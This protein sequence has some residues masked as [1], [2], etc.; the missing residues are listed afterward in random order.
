M[1]SK[2]KTVLK[3]VFLLAI[4]SLAIHSFAAWTMPT[5]NPPEG[6]TP[7]PVNT[8]SGLQ[9]KP[10]S[11]LVNLFRVF[12]DAY[13][14]GNVGVG[15]VTPA[16][17]LDV[18]GPGVRFSNSGNGIEFLQSNGTNWQIANIGTNN[19][20]SVNGNLGV[21]TTTPA[22]KLDVAGTVK[23]TGFQLTTG[24]GA[25]KILTSDLNGVATWQTP[26][27][28]SGL[29]AGTNGQT[30]RNNNGTWE[31][32]SSIFNN[33]TNVGI[34]NTNP[35]R[36]LDV[37]GD[38]KFSGSLLPNDSAGLAGQVLMTN[39]SG[40]TPYWSTVVGE[41]GPQGEQGI[42]GIQGIQGNQG[43]QG[44]QGIQ[45]NQGDPGP[46][47][48]QGIQ[49]NQG[50]QG[51]PGPPGSGSMGGGGTAT[52]I[53]KFT[54]ANEL[55]DSVIYNQSD[56]D[57]GINTTSPG[58]R[59]GIAGNLNVGSGYANL[60]GQSNGAIIE[61][62]VG[63]GTSSPSAKLH[64]AG[65]VRIVDGNQSYGDVLTS[66]ANGNAT[67]QPTLVPITGV[68]NATLNYNAGAY[69]ISTFL[70]N[71][72]NQVGVGAGQY[73]PDLF[74][75]GTPGSIRGLM[76]LASGT[77]G[78]AI[79][80]APS[81]GFTTYTL[82]LPTDDGNANQFLKTNG[83]GALSWD[84]VGTSIDTIGDAGGPGT[85]I[86]GNNLQEWTWDTLSSTTGF[87]LSSSTPNPGSG[88]TL[89]NVTMDGTNNGG[90]TAM[91]V[92]NNKTGTANTNV[93]GQFSSTGGLNDYAILVPPNSGFVGIGDSNPV[94]LF[95][96][97]S[98]DTFQV[99]S[100]GNLSKIRG[101]TYAWPTVQGGN[102]QVL[103]NDGNGTLTWAAGGGGGV[104]GSGAAPYIP[105]WTGST[106]L[107]NS[108]IQ[109]TGTNVGIGSGTPAN[110]LD[111]FGGSIRAE[112]S[113][114]I[115]GASSGGLILKETTTNLNDIIK[116]QAPASIAGSYTLTLPTDNGNVDQ[117]LRTDGNGVLS[118]V[119]PASGGGITTLNTLGGAIQ[120]FATGTTGTNF[121]ITSSG[122]T[123]TFNL[124]DASVTN[125]GVVT[126]GTQAFA[127]AKNFVDSP[128]SFG[129]ATGTTAGSIRIYDNDSTG[130]ENIIINPPAGTALTSSYTLTLPTGPGTSGQV[131]STNGSGVLSWIAAGGGLPSGTTNQTLRHNGTTWLA[132]SLITNQG[133]TGNVGIGT[134]SPSNKLTVNENVGN[135]T[136]SNHATYGFALK[137]NAGTTQFTLG[138]NSTNSYIQSWDGQPLYING[139]LNNTTVINPTAGRVGVGTTA[140]T[141]TFQISQGNSAGPGTVM[142]SPNSSTLSGSGTDF[143]NTFAVGDTVTVGA[144]GTRT[145]TSISSATS[146]QINPP[147]DSS[148][149]SGLSYTTPVN[150][151]FAARGNGNIGINNSIPT[152]LLDINGNNIR[153]R[154]AKT[155]AQGSVCDTGEISWDANYM[156]VCTA[157]NVWKRAS[158]TT[159]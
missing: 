116:I 2:I 135:T 10:G 150:T 109:D 152:D 117:I 1:H 37:T 105:K 67:W 19:S 88:G 94:E 38:I 76:S 127:G 130:P 87:R 60:P 21:G 48:I 111:V 44:P 63:I 28:G 80:Q 9:H 108:I 43:D 72:G 16:R 110:K 91:L 31:A 96:V 73:P 11:L 147:W 24:A 144:E 45:G 93:A 29:P 69:Q 85:V 77:S 47:G 41:Q 14:D 159:Y 99:N 49:G 102:G 115:T 25:D 128:T 53:P 112:N 106:T 158:L 101:V 50:D 20:L 59:L 149:F 65:S 119:D 138:T 66:D 145:I 89:F 26:S 141:A 113:M 40:T 51:P 39:G 86:V 35:G 134:S 92:T 4:F 125:R 123:H 12:G 137:D 95:T 62:N 104:G 118:W 124:P 136:P 18:N 140:P 42:Q 81:T 75:I 56:G 17:K 58:A 70:S 142:A 55:G 68:Q 15:T 54:A 84:D 52:Y 139:Y 57:I 61:G 79:I 5:Y 46:Q 32:T 8:G 154:T 23:A 3:S 83:L 153:I 132:D 33:G 133:G 22:T 121:G 148:G 129:D 64:V 82:T 146:M 34:G 6:N 36:K 74:S 90:T 71:S 143:Q 131:L 78:K 27:A 98:G 7:A 114:I 126:T 103:T 156:Y 120:T 13:F 122:T 107:G 97:G 155:P 151:V 157:T 30:V 100:S